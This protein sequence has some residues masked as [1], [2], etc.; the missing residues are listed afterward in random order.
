MTVI[1]TFDVTDVR[2]ADAI[3]TGNAGED[4]DVVPVSRPFD[5]SVNP[6][7]TLVEL[8]VTIAFEGKTLADN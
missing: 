7:G 1:G 8:K 2:P 3:V 4:T 6:A 5:V